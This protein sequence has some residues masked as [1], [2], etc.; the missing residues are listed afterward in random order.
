MTLVGP[1]MR[2]R[3]HVPACVCSLQHALDTP[4]KHRGDV[5]AHLDAGGLQLSCHVVSG[6]SAPGSQRHIC[7]GCS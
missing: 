6:S 4:A 1:V 7:T 3:L 2:S 5:A